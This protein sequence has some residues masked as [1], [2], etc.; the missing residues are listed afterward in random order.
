MFAK[1]PRNLDNSKMRAINQRQRRP[2]DRVV[3]SSK[4]ENAVSTRGVGRRTGGE[5]RCRAPVV[6]AQFE[7][8]Q[9]IIGRGGQCKAAKRDEQ[10]LNGNG[11]GNNDPDQRSPK[12]PRF[13][14]V[15][16]T[17]THGGNVSIWLNRTKAD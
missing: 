15:F 4:T 6:Q 14:A 12:S 17:P 13:L 8:R 2:N 1:R 16:E 7:C 9:S 10:A 3:Y 5:G 11:I